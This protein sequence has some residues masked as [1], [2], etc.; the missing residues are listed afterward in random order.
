MN[1]FIVSSNEHGP[2]IEREGYRY[3]RDENG[4]VLWTLIGERYSTTGLS[5]SWFSV[6]RLEDELWTFETS[7]NAISRLIVVGSEEEID[8]M[9]VQKLRDDCYCTTG[10][11]AAL[12][13]ALPLTTAFLVARELEGTH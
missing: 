7:A 4:E 1:S 10:F 8:Q 5:C 6:Y 9:I 13:G 12:P 3:V 2:A 11:R